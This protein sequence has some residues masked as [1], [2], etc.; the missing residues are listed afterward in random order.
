MPRKKVKKGRLLELLVARLEEALGPEGATIKSPDRL[1]DRDTGELR[2]V[3]VSIRMRTGSVDLLMI[4]EC[5]DRRGRQDSRWIEE[6]SEK[7]VSVGADKVLAVARGG[8]TRPAERKARARLIECRRLD[9]LTPESVLQTLRLIG[10]DLIKPRSHLL[11]VHVCLAS[12]EALPAGGLEEAQR[13]LEKSEGSR[14]TDPAFRW[15]SGERSSL[16][17]LWE[18]VKK[19][20][21]IDLFAGVPED[22]TQVRRGVEAELAPRALQVQLP[23]GVTAPVRHITWTFDLWQEIVPLEPASAHA[24]RS[25]DDQT[26]VETLEYRIDLREDGG[27]EEILSFHRDVHTGRVRVSRRAVDDPEKELPVCLGTTLVRLNRPPSK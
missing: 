19:A 7:R 23:W 17:G 16:L 2:E 25:P 3:D 10:F 8:F 22:G 11:D 21:K 26:F 24:Y 13:L 4:A 18:D 27:D 6:L 9:S 12:P 1:P 14:L 15:R 5:R 20:S